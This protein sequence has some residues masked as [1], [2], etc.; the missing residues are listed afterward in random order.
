MIVFILGTIF[1]V[2]SVVSFYVDP[3]DENIPVTMTLMLL[4]CLFFIMGAIR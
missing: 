2:M 1:V 3:L 4:G